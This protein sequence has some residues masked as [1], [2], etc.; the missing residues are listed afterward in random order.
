M[1]PAITKL[2]CCSMRRDVRRG[3]R[4]E[5]EVRGRDR[6]AVLIGLS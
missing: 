5:I 4:R 1:L 6:D 2:L 3:A